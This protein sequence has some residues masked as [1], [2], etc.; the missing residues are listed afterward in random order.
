MHI[1]VFASRFRSYRTCDGCDGKRFKPEAL[2]YKI[3]DQ[4]IA[5]IL[6]MQAI[7]ADAFFSDAPLNEREQ[8]IAREPLRQVRDR[9]G[10]LRTVG[11]EYLQLD[12][13]LRTL[14]GGETQRVAL[15]SALGGSLVNMLYVLDEPT[16]GLHPKD[17][18]R[19]CK[20]I[21][22]LRDRGNTVIVVE[23]NETMIRSSDQVLE[24]GPGAGVEGGE[25]VFQGT[26]KQMM[27]S[28]VSLTGQYLTGNRGQTLRHHDPRQPRG[29]ITLRRASG[30][31]LR[32]VTADFPLGVLC[33]VTGV[34]GSG[35]S[36]LVQ[37]HA[38]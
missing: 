36:S 25:L 26:P 12:R 30:H 32:D 13:P 31:N 20:A 5:D 23:H 19:L 16:A 4:S 29:R 37:G 33:V 11:L 28:K 24:I 21:E 9:L 34:S 1:R 22:R 10:Y 27:N 18:D 14:S 17:V 6:T 2:A 8:E 38:L 7:V 3:G 15:T 35:K